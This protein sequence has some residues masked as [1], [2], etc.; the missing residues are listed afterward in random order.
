MESWCEKCA[1]TGVSDATK[2]RTHIASLYEI[3]FNASTGTRE[4]Q[5]KPHVTTKNLKTTKW[6]RSTL[7]LRHSQ[8]EVQPACF[9]ANGEML[10]KYLD[11]N[12]FGEVT[13]C[14]VCPKHLNLCNWMVWFFACF[15]PSQRE[16]HKMHLFIQ[17]LLFVSILRVSNRSCQERS[18]RQINNFQWI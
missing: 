16:R 18:V 11:E 8:P 3:T 15:K 7:H 9:E 13:E 10:S 14:N 5:K 2:R 1:D 6:K 17:R 12:E 4:S